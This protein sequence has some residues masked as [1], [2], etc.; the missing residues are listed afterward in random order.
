MLPFSP[1]AP[2]MDGFPPDTG[3]LFA[4]IREKGFAVIPD[5]VPATDVALAR[6]K[7]DAV[8]ALQEAETT[9]DIMS[10][11][12][13]LDIARL[14][15]AHDSWFL[16]FAAHSGVL[17]LM[18][19][20]IGNYIVLG[21]Q[22]G[23]INRPGRLH[24][25]SVW[26]RDLPYQEWTCS[27]PLAISALFCLDPFTPET[28]CTHVLPRSH[29]KDRLPPVD[30]VEKH[31][32]PVSAAAGSVI[33]FDCMLFHRAGSNTSAQIRRGINHVYSIP[34]FK[35]QID[36]PRALGRTWAED[37]RLAELLGYT[38]QSSESVKTWREARA[39]R[40]GV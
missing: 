5:V 15:L 16:K 25:Q 40:R 29:Q 19:R 35:Q 31:A 28:G 14:P 22:N 26:H 18:R 6:S 37:P 1:G 7:L 10:K 20:L 39:A 13:D 21:L 33:I 24:P 8:Y 30:Y 23:I 36:L 32:V 27:K 4:D 11:I 3:A 38:S 17:A 12:Q 9:Y 2:E 34:L